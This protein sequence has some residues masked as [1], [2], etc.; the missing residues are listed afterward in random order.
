MDLCN[1]SRHPRYVD[2]QGPIPRKVVKFNPG[3]SLI[4]SKIFLSKNT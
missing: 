4:L 3:L 2:E 1:L